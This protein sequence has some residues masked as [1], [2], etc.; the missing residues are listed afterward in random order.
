MRHTVAVLLC[1]SVLATTLLPQRVEAGCYRN[2]KTRP[3]LSAEDQYH[4]YQPTPRRSKHDLPKH[5]NWCNLDGKNW[6]S[7]SWNQH[8]PKY[9][10]SC[11]LHGTL[12]MIQDRIAIQRGSGEYVM[13]GRQSLLN[14]AP[15]MGYSEGCN[16]GDP[17]DV[18]RYMAK[19]GLPDEGCYPYEATDH[20]K[21]PSGTKEC[22]ADGFCRN[23]MPIN[24]TDTCWAV[25]TPLVYTLTAY[26][27]VTPGDEEGMMSE[28]HANGPIV[29]S[30][31]TPDEFVY[32]Y[33]G[34]IWNGFNDTDVD[35]N[36]EVVGWGEED[37][38][39]FWVIRNSWGTY[40][41]ELGFFRLPRGVNFFS[42]E[43]D[44]CW[45]ATPDWSMERQVLAGELQGS[46]YG[47]QARTQQR[48]IA[49]K[50]TMD[51]LVQQ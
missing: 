51:T 34:G 47:L 14:C 33:H 32:G 3:Q 18:F 10:G 22:P 20:T 45:V 5:F 8:I 36:V 48:T 17:I 1:A 9:C 11:W 2:G 12:S 28:I 49:G 35:H 40:W 15:L 26:G 30:I 46:M 29:C 24:G 16:G 44:D 7:P 25:E 50:H 39:P 43:G 38:T 4:N 23:C 37:G 41:G 31:A 19:K 13:L 6:C 21:Y 27:K 42:I